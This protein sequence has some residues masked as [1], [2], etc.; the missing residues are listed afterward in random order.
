MLT[1]LAKKYI[2]YIIYKEY[3]EL[4]SNTFMET[5]YGL[6]FCKTLN[7]L[8]N[9]LATYICLFSFF[10]FFQIFKFLSEDTESSKINPYTC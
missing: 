6:I 1:S 7:T 10:L 3:N 9:L 5:Y 4:F 8:N 2:N